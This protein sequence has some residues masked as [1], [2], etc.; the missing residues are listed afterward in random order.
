[1]VQQQLIETLGTLGDRRAT[2]SVIGKLRDDNRHV[3]RVA[4]HAL[5]YLGDR[6]AIEAVRPL[7]FAYGGELWRETVNTLQSL[8]DPKLCALLL[9]TLSQPDCEEHHGVA[10]EALAELYGPVQRILVQMRPPVL[11]TR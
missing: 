4:L 8:D 7:L 5:S 2:A 10:I 9:A 3:Q 6:T 1:M 11:Y